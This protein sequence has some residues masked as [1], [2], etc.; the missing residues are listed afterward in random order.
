MT[1]AWP[2]AVYEDEPDEVFL[3]YSGIAVGLVLL[4]GLMS[5]LTLALLPLDAVDLEV[6]LSIVTTPAL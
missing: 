4:A 5:G 1:R 3:L 2:G 6:T